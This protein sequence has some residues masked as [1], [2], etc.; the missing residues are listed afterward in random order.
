MLL[1]YLLTIVGTIRKHKCEIPKYLKKD[2]E[3]GSPRF[4][5]DPDMT[6]VFYSL[7]K[8]KI[9]LLLSSC[10]VNGSINRETG[11]T[12]IIMLYN[13]NKG[14]PDSFNQLCHEYSLARKTKQ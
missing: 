4:G 7:K 1:E 2:A 10:I 14:G 13:S 9:F 12:E 5:Y 8:N 11:K 6:L 3:F